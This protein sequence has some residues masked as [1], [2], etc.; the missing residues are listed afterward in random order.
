MV[1]LYYTPV[2]W[3][4][5]HENTIDSF[6]MM[7]NNHTLIWAI[8]LYIFFILFYNL[9]GMMV[10]QTYSAVYRTILEAVRTLCIWI[11]NLIIYK[12]IDKR[13]GEIWSNWSWLE[14]VIYILIFS[15][16]SCLY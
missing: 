12:F 6:K 9:Y 11:T 4:A 13:F 16:D 7:G 15:S 1:P 3:E 5:F 2:S 14:A 10:T 8:L